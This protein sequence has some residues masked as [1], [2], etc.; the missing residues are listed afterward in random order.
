[1]DSDDISVNTRFEEQLLFFLNN[2]KID[3]VGGNIEEFVDDKKNIIGKRVVPQTNEKIRKYMKK[4]C[5]F[6]HMSVMYKKSSVQDAG[7]Y[8]DW[9]WDEDYYLWIRM[10]LN[11]CVFANTGTTLV[12][13]RV[14]DN[15]YQRRGGRKY[16]ESE[17][18]LQKYMLDHKMISWP[19]Y[20][21]N[22]VKRYVLQI[23]FPNNVRAFVYQK[24]A[25]K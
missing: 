23:M 15:M 12:Y 21:S 17:K 3:I 24:F 14:D 8:Q 10:W 16:Y 6:N 22:V 9:F 7:G 13:V 11:N 2:P 19:V 4:R 18:K 1:M 5:P 20:V 25:R